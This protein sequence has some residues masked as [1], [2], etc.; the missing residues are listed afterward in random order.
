MQTS[1]VFDLLDSVCSLY[2]TRFLS[3]QNVEGILPYLAHD[4]KCKYDEKDGNCALRALLL[5]LNV[6]VKI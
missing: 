6:K 5:Q 3:A 4:D 2:S 1:N